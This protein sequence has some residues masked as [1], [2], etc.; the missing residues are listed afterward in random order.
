MRGNGNSGSDFIFYIARPGN[1]IRG[2]MLQQSY[3]GI[4]LDTAASTGNRIVGNFM[5]FNT[6]YTLGQR[7]HAGVWLNNGAH[8][9]FIGTP[10]LADRNVVGNY[11]KGIYSY[12]SG[13]NH[14]TIQNNN[15][16]LRPNGL[17]ASCATGIDFDFGPKSAL[18]GGSGAGEFNVVG[19]TTLNG[20]ELSHGWD[21]ATNHDS[22]LAWQI[23][24]N[25]IIGNWV[26]FKADGNYDPAYRS[27]LQAPSSDNGQ[28]IHAHDGCNYNLIEGNYVAA[29]YDGITVAMGNSTGNIVHDNIIGVSPLGQPAPMA[30][31]GIYLT[32]NTRVNTVLGN[33]I[34][35][36]AG[37]G[38][39]LIDPNVKQIRISQN[40]VSDT[41]GPAIYLAP[42]PNDPSIGANDLLAAPV[43][44]SASESLVAGTG[45][46]DATVEVFQASRNPGQFGLPIEYLGSTTVT[47]DGHWSIALTLI[48]GQK[49][50]AT[51]IAVNG[52]T[53]ALAANA[54]VGSAP[55]PPVS[56]FTWSQ[57]A[58]ALTVAFTDV[59]TGAPSAWTWDF[60]D[61]TTSNEQNP[62]KAYSQP[63]DYTV[64]LTVTNGSGSDF[65]SRLVTVSQIAVGTMLA[66]DAFNR[67]IGVGWGASDIGGTYGYDG[68]VANFSVSNTSGRIVL[69]STNANRAALL[70][71]VNARDV[72]AQV[73]VTL[74]HPATGSPAYAYLLLRRNGGNGYRPKLIFN[75]NGT[76]SVHV[77]ALVNN[78]ESPLGA[79]V[80]VPGLTQ[81]G[82]IW[83]RAQVLGSN[84]TTIN[85]K[86][87]ADGQPE[88]AAWQF[89]ATDSRAALQGAG[90]VGLRAYL[91]PGSTNTPY[92][93]RFDDLNVTAAALPAAGAVAAD[94]FGRTVSAGW[95]NADVGGKYTLQGAASNYNV[96]GTAGTILLTGANQSRSAMLDATSGANVDMVFRVAADKV[97]AGG[98]YYVYCAARRNGTNEYRPRLLFNANG[99]VSVGASLL[100]SGAESALAASVVVPGL[101]QSANGY[102]WVRAQATGASPTTINVKAWADG[103]AEPAGWQFTATDSMAAV[104]VAGSVGL[105]VYITGSVTTA[106]VTFSF[107]DLSI[108]ILP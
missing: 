100:N 1:T 56:D 67:T 59:S 73:R 45:I 78:A 32:L 89:T 44:T 48:A 62:T 13:T 40:I 50:T 35:N 74:D 64:T 33:I 49:V 96:N 72:D 9:N 2:L 71:D 76:V 20:I 61:G 5:G 29:A 65:H 6:D 55:P 37:G 19:P 15:V 8:D 39:M 102:I 80:V 57:S 36:A 27:A 25:Q 26:G 54:N 101:T 106:P 87:W 81:N 107:D 47:S 12:G 60:G 90:G 85:V 68:S 105:R 84:P 4:F 31:Y 24:D 41:N 52:D 53:S 77:G 18:V 51:Q 38:I 46:A 95:G 88:P 108:Q 66:S 3:S 30:R 98:T 69:S 94:A 10:A 14:N 7:G 83:I 82:Y 16:C 97:A 79:A 93:F 17:G 104:Q 91:A 92:S 103:Q 63:G 21:P 43:I 23:N 58:G 11:D 22:T 34:R 70:N 86:A 75:T 99:T 42:D 28:A